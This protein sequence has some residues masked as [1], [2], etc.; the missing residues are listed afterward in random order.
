MIKIAIADAVG[1]VL[2]YDITVVD[3][4]NKHKGVAFARGHVIR[5]E[6]LPVLE[7]IGKRNIYIWEGNEAEV[8]EDDAAIRLAPQIAGEHIRF[9]EK[10]KEGKIGFYATCPGLFEVDIER[11]ERINRLAIPSLPTINRYF[12]V[13]EGKQVAAFRIIPLTCSQEIMTAI[14]AEL[15]TPLLQIRPYQVKKAAIL[16]T[17]SEVFSGKIKDGFTPKLTAK[18]KALGIEV[19][20]SELL[21]DEKPRI[22]EAIN[23]A[24]DKAELLLITGGTSVD[25]D[26]VTVAA[27]NEA[28]IDFPHKGNPIQ[29]GNNLTIGYARGKTVCA[30][31][32]AALFFAATALDI[33]LPRMAAGDRITEDEIARAGHGGLCHFCKVCHY[34]ICPFGRFV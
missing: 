23:A 25:P 6:D 22:S 21:P 18:L 2:G 11:L 14:E 16:V 30:V 32:A 19:V 10:P 3:P 29:P 24:L 7:R 31:P 27:M 8:H 28:G 15:E 12:P 17:G 13:T 9:D 34:P 26:D 33:F 20:H 4:E 5:E 1:K